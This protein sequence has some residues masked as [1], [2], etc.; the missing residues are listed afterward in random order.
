MKPLLFI[1]VVAYS[2]LLIG[3][4]S[5]AGT[6]DIVGKVFDEYTKEGI[7]KRVVIIQSMILSD[8]QL[9]P[10][11]EVGRF[12][13]DSTGHFNYTLKKTK[14][15][16]WYN[17]V[18]V[19]DST[20]SYTAQARCI[21]ELEQNAKFLSF[22]LDKFTDFRIMIERI[23]KTVPFDTLYISWRTNDFDG[24]IYPRKV[25]NYGIAPDLEFRWIGGNVKSFIEAKTFANKNT[26]V[27]MDLFR[28]GR[29]KKM[30][31][32]IYCYRDVK[33]Y[34]TFKY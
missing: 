20:Y 25:I 18:F 13:T 21:T 19:G 29:L 14:N 23:N 3:C 31:D 2:L 6:V 9:I 11:D 33:N 30:T 27:H 32:T 34:F 22:Y 5:T 26:I 1:V 15:V 17:F 7:P 28:K 4:T 24:K 12:Y 16:Y 10:V 8:S